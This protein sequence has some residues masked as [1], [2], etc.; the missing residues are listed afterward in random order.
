MWALS[1][2]DAAQ[3]VAE[4]HNDAGQRTYSCQSFCTETLWGLI[5]CRT[6]A[7]PSMWQVLCYLQ[8]Y[9]RAA[10]ADAPLPIPSVYASEFALTLK[11]GKLTIS[12]CP[13]F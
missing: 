5:A 3:Q 11:N 2:P 10:G 13:A 12:R 7:Q 9:A 8:V 4:V 6:T 1:S